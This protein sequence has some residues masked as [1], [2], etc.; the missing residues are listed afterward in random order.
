MALPEFL[1]ARSVGFW[2]VLVGMLA[3]VVR[4][5]VFVDNYGVNLLFYDQWILWDHLFN[6]GGDGA[7]A[8]FWKEHGPVRIGVGAYVMKAL[9]ELTDMNTR[10]EGF[11]VA[12]ILVIS[13][14]L[15]LWL[16]VRLVGPLRWQDLAIPLMFL[17]LRHSEVL[18]GTMMIHA[19][20]L[21]ILFLLAAALGLTV[22]Q[23][24]LR[25]GLFLLFASLT[26]WAGF[27]LF[28]AFIAPLVLISEC[29]LLIR[30][31]QRKAIWLPI[32]GLVLLAGE[33]FLYFNGYHMK[34]ASRCFQFPHDP[35]WE[36]FAFLAYQ[37][38]NFLLGYTPS[39][40]AAAL[41]WFLLFLVLGGAV[42]W[43]NFARSWLAVDRKWTSVLILLVGFSVL[44]SINCAI[45]RVCHWDKAGTTLRYYPFLLP[46]FLGVYLAFSASS[47]RTILTI[48][49]FFLMVYSE[50]FQRR[51]L[52]YARDISQK[53]TAWIK[54]YQHYGNI[55][56]A[57]EASGLELFPGEKR[58]P[59]LE[60]Q[61]I[62]LREEKLNLFIE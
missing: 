16:K 35:I 45:G 60:K 51:P 26:L 53:K 14:L 29:L 9:F 24:F 62:Q 48:C 25:M 34:A 56:E 58:T 6:D 49:F 46:I 31:G 50:F 19:S 61:L 41:L 15:A 27:G 28:V 18:V 1:R 23:R 59:T 3:L 54:S 7:S 39:G 2:F 30:S 8:L 43:R 40:L 22:K 42:V 11:W 12:G 4:L 36:Y 44:F 37:Y 20:S 55:P 21:P 10:S 47:R 33:L 5:F 38:D 52:E 57:N 17:S 13:S 32:L